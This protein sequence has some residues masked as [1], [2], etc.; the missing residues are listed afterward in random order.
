VEKYAE[1]ERPKRLKDIFGPRLRWLSAGGAP[2]PNH[3]AEG[4]WKC[5]VKL[6]QGYGLTESSPVITFNTI[7]Q[8]KIGT[9]GRPISG[10]EVKIAD[11]GE[12]L[13]R[14]PNIMIGYWNKPQATAEAIDA[15]GWL[16]TGDLGSMDE[17]G[18][19]SITGRKKDL[20]VL[21]NGKKVAPALIESLLLADAYIDQ[22]VAHGDRRRF[23][24]ALIVPNFTRL[25]ERARE[26]GLESLPA[27]ELVRTPEVERFFEER[28]Q[29]CLSSVSP[30]ERVKRFL[31]LD[32]PFTIADDELTTTLKYRR[33]VI[34]R[35]HKRS[36]DVLYNDSD[37]AEVSGP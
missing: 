17:D 25:A 36:L 20:I 23:L 26:W 3:V 19:V 31:L 2:L 7:K 4:F 30:Q 9:I 11:D 5:G 29:V 34:F 10:V 15:D 8:N 22:A 27:S 13:A 14:G 32:R 12:V 35:K 6:L 33:Q 37:V 21:S 16:H 28:L 24:S 1:A 18:F